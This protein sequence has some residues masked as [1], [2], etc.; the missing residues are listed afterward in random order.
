MSEQPG[1]GNW[2]DPPGAPAEQAP[3][4]AAGSATGQAPGAPGAANGQR[5]SSGNGHGASH[6]AGPDQRARTSDFGRFDWFAE[7][8]QFGPATSAP[9]PLPPPAIRARK[10]R[11]RPGRRAVAICGLALACTALGGLVG[12]FVAVHAIDNKPQDSSYSLGAVP[13]A[14]SGRPSN[15]VAGI[16]SRDTPS[17]VMIKVNGTD[18][19]GS[20]FVIAGGYIVTDNHVV[21]LDGLVPHASL[22]VYFSNGKS[23]RAQL[24]GR[25][26]FSDIAVIKAVGVTDLPALSLGNSA[27]VAVGD[28]VIAIG[29][30]LGL[31]D[32]VTSGI[33]SAVDRPV[34]PGTNTSG[35]PAAYF[36]AIQT[37]A[38]INPG[39]SGG[40]L[41]NARGQVIGMDA[42]IDTLGSDPITGT[43]GG[44]IGLGFAIPINQVRRV[45]VELIKTGRATHSVIGAGISAG[46]SGVGAQISSASGH[47]SKPSIT[48]GGPA[49]KAGLRPGDVIIRFGNQ[50]VTDANSLLDGIRSL[51]P[52]TRVTITFRR[53]GQTLKTRVTLG[54]AG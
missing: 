39:N 8:E 5:A 48:P 2:A 25:D 4:P 46:Y 41:V 6:T 44:S 18:G 54:S 30:P 10:R 50:A 9:L 31:T 32:T 38:P 21:T 7:S 1:R 52:G 23:A 26:P 22:E 12:G 11:L 28:T 34:Q 17:V 47:D 14:P 40:P 53:G 33:V 19:T 20:G 36:D 16:A 37:D 43:Q 45:A 13:S 15:S 51:A 27:R 42:A 3:E 35:A 24:V 49:A 29:S